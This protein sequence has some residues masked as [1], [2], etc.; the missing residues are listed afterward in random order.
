MLNWQIKH[1]NDLSLTEFHD[2]IALRIKVFVVEQDCP[3]QELDGKD[4]KSYHLLC[5]NE[6][7][8]LVGTFR[9]LPPGVS[10]EEASIGRVVL[11]EAYRGAKNGHS[12]MREA[13]AFINKEFNRENVRISGQKYLEKFYEK[14][15]FVSTEKEY[16]EDGI[17]HVE[18]ILNYKL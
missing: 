10:Y 15:G 17:P 7:G 6:Y 16:L 11:D 3:Y 1:F 9:I 13:I 18:M 8:D 12:M 5:R 2:I 14:H 4:K